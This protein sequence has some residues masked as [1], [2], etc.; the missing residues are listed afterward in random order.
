[1]AERDLGRAPGRDRFYIMPWSEFPETFRAD[2]ESF[3]TRKGPSFDDDLE[4][5]V[6]ADDDLLRDEPPPQRKRKVLKEATKENYRNGFRRIASILVNLGRPAS[7]IGALA[8]IV[9]VDDT[10]AVI[11]HLR[12]RLSKNDGGHISYLA[13][14]MYFAARDHV[15]LN[16][17]QVDHLEEIWRKVRGEFGK[18]S[19]RSFDRLVQ[20]DD[21]DHKYRMA[22][23]SNKL[24][25][26]A[27]RLQSIDARSIRLMRTAVFVAIGLDTAMRSGNIVSLTLD[28]HI[29]LHQA[30][31]KWFGEILVPGQEVKNGVEIVSPLQPETVAL[32][33]E[34][35][36]DY[37]PFVLKEKG[38]ACQYLFP[39]EAGGHLCRT[40]ATESMKDLGGKYAGLDVT[41]HVM[42]AYMGKVILDESP[43][44]HAQVQELLGHKSL[45]TTVSSYAPVRQMQARQRSQRLLMDLRGRK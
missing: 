2:I 9:T 25:T 13:F 10:I 37:R 4:R 45:K 34:W 14:L 19:R 7:R 33:R 36:A 44:A 8:D 22:D 23:F 6:S 27:R 32:I 41:P 38:A 26:A 43:D 1:V 11:R 12:G 18:M 35:I 17:Q 29:T 30:K 20:F 15:K 28:R 3:I 39:N 31:K 24:A 16:S 42:R 5:I 21:E 40:I